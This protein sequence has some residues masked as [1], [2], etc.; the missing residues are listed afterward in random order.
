MARRPSRLS[1]GTLRHL[2]C[3]PAVSGCLVLST[4]QATRIGPRQHAGGYNTATSTH[5]LVADDTRQDW[6]E[7][8]ASRPQGWPSR[9]D[10]EL[11]QGGDTRCTHRHPEINRKKEG[12]PL[13]P[14]STRLL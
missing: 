10:A 6:D 4:G 5:R 1:P 9:P 3:V 2:S 7:H 13:C 12:G 14:Q 8:S 11:Q